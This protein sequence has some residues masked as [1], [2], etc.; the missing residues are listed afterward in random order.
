MKDPTDPAWKDDIGLKEWSS[1]MDKYFP[2]GDKTSSFTVYGYTWSQVL[3]A[4]LEQCGDD[5]TRTNVMRQASNLKN[6]WFGMLLPGITV[7]TGPNDYSPVKQFQM[8]RFDGE[9]LAPF[10]PIISGEIPGN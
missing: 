6:L 9:H 5:L 10:G 1:F 7:N 8:T 3:V 4:V 2:D